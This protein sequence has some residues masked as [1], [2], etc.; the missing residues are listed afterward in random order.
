MRLAFT[1]LG[2]L[3][4]GCASDFDP[5]IEH[6]G[7]EN[8]LGESESVGEPSSDSAD[9]SASEEDSGSEDPSAGSD[10]SDDGSEDEGSDDSNGSDDG[11]ESGEDTGEPVPAP[12]LGEPCDPFLAFSGE[13][14]CQAD[15][16]NPALASTCIPVQDQI[17]LTWEFLCVSVEDTQG[18]GSDLGDPCSDNE[19]AAAHAGCFNSLCLGNGLGT[20]PETDVYESHP[21]IPSEDAC[22]FLWF[23]EDDPN[24][25]G[26]GYYVK[27]CCSAFC[28]A[29]NPCEAGWTC[30][31]NGLVPAEL[32]GEAV[33][34]CVW[35]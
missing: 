12:A 24:H 11:S 4:C 19:G 3:L 20:S 22:P 17:E 31:M 9:D 1:L 35:E 33:G 30:K 2:A 26:G 27:G 14:P 18:D 13:A 5:S 8:S 21:P 25:E 29:E 7:D 16:E 28:D 15:P 34:V 23:P 32:N 10:E 6:G